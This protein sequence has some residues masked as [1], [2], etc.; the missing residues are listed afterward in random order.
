M[1]SL[2]NQ[3]D[4]VVKT[5]AGHVPNMR[6]RRCQLSLSQLL[7]YKWRRRPRLPVK[8]PAAAALPPTPLRSARLEGS[9]L[10][11]CHIVGCERPWGVAG[12]GQGFKR[13]KFQGFNV[14]KVSEFTPVALDPLKPW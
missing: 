14:S 10:Q 4:A 12:W 6:N 9:A 3:D 2:S 5:L 13:A 7:L 1:S 8:T 11:F